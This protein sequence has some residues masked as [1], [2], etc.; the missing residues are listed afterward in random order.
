MYTGNYPMIIL[1]VN[2][3]SLFKKV[4]QY[5]DTASFSCKVQGSQL[6]EKKVKY[7]N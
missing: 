3:S 1:N 5:F 7:I 2:I 4:I 6:M